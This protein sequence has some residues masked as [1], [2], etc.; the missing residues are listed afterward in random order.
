MSQIPE[1]PSIEEDCFR[2]I[3]HITL[4]GILVIDENALVCYCNE[5]ANSY[6][7]L[8]AQDIV[9]KSIYSLFSD[10][11]NLDLCNEIQC[12]LSNKITW[13]IGLH[14]NFQTQLEGTSVTILDLT[15]HPVNWSSRPLFITKINNGSRFFMEMAGN[16]ELGEEAEKKNQIFHQKLRSVVEGCAVAYNDSV[17]FQSLVKNLATTLQVRC[18]F[19]SE[20]TGVDTAKTLALWVNNDFKEN[21]EYSLVDTPCENIS[22]KAVQYYP[23]NLQK[24][25]PKDNILIDWGVDNYMSLPFFDATGKPL[26][27]LGLMCSKPLED[28]EIMHTILKIFSQYAGSA[29]ERKRIADTLKTSY[30]RLEASN[31]E[32]RDFVHIASH[33]LQEP[34]RKIISFGDLLKWSSNT[35]DDEGTYFLER[36]KSSTRRLQSLLNDLVKFSTLDS[37]INDLVDTVNL[38]TTAQQVLSDLDIL[39]SRTNT[40]VKGGLKMYQRGGVKVYHSGLKKM[41]S[42]S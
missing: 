32:L 30:H 10:H 40:T 39:K 23:H 4:D 34:L 25:F 21:I 9:G 3:A 5:I 42:R 31:E 20:L 19:V 18:V 38:T 29:L 37:S 11:H 14:K 8:P 6:F 22:N 33:D 12:F 26:G 7:D 36:M 24:L 17:F 2:S 35:L 41:V 1:N 15:I 27:H 13:D 28:P 16:K